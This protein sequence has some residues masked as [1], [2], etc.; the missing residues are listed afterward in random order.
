MT[1]NERETQYRTIARLA[2][3]GFTYGEWQA[4]RRISMTLSRWGELE[5]GD[6]NNYSSWAIERDEKTGKP[7]R[8]VYPHMGKSRRYPVADREKGALRRMEKIMAGHPGYVGYYQTDPRG[9]AVYVVRVSDLEG[10]DI[11]SLYTRGV[12]VGT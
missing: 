12:A 4:L 5:C 1:K 2:D 7:Y 10:G 8:V 11:D 6:S 9:C 3:W